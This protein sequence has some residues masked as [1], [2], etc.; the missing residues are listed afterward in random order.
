MRVSVR[1]IAD[2]SAGRHVLPMRA[3]AIVP[4]VDVL[5]GSGRLSAGG[6]KAIDVVARIVV[7]SLTQDQESNLQSITWKGSP[8]EVGTP[9]KIT[10]IAEPDTLTALVRRC[11]DP[12]DLFGGD[13]RSTTSCRMATFGYDGQA[14]VCLRHEDAA[15][16]SPDASLVMIEERS[17]WLVQT[18]WF[19]GS[20]PNR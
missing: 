16:K 11:L 1:P 13:V 18:D 15:P 17:E 5:D 19:D 7:D 14:Y 20:W 6:S 10:A 4:L 9:P 8:I 2:I 3:F 12:N